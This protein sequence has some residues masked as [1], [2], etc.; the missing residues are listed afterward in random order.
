MSEVL[1]I[2]DVIS[3]AQYELITSL[4]KENNILKEKVA[5]LEQTLQSRIVPAMIPITEEE[6][7]CIEQINILKSASNKRELSLDEVK[8]LDL[9]IK[10]LRLIR[11]PSTKD[12][13]FIDYTNMKEADLVAVLNSP[14]ETNK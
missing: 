6:I 13:G 11:E 1:S 9:L 7:I 5:Y 12:V 3:T 14:S 10:N 2:D 8:R 4:K